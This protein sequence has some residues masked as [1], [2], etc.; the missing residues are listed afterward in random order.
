MP[1][2]FYHLRLANDLLETASC[3]DDIRIFLHTWRYEFM[4]GSIVP[5]VQV[6][7]GQPREATH[8]FNL[9]LRPEDQPAWWVMLTLYPQLAQNSQLTPAHTAFMAGYLCHLQA[10]WYWVNEI[11]LPVFG[12][13]CSWGSFSDRLYYHNVLRAYLDLQIQPGLPDNLGDGLARVNPANWLPFTPDR[14]LEKWRD[15]VYPQLHPGAAI[16]TVEVFSS[17]QGT[18][19][20]EYYAILRSPERMRQ[21]IFSQ[22]SLE[23]VHA[24]HQSTISQ[25]LQLLSGYLASSLHPTLAY[26]QGSVFTGVQP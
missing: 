10:D 23:Q 16:Q 19:P 11:F 24:Y 1:T 14:F 8:F 18:A 22:I 3:R 9:P 20:P 12:P 4:L 26:S 17:R 15:F 13:T 7:S 25:N 21:E 2:P 6:V 5:D